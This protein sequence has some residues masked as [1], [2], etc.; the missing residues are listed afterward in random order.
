MLKNRHHGTKDNIPGDEWQDNDWDGFKTGCQSRYRC[1]HIAF[2]NVIYCVQ[3]QS[4]AVRSLVNAHDVC[5]HRWKSGDVL[6]CVEKAPAI[7]YLSAASLN[8]LC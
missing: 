4:Q 3:K 6:Y 7:L 5:Q 8:G 2:V 1:I